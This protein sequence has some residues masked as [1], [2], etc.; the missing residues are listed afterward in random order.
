MGRPYS[1][2]LRVRVVAAMEGGG[3]CRTVGAAFGIAPSTAGNRHRL[4]RRTQGYSARPMGGDRRSKLLDHDAHVAALLADTC[5][6]R[7]VDV[8]AALAERGVFVSWSTVRRRV[9]RLGLRLKKKRYSRRNRIAL[10]SRWQ[11]S[12]G[13]RL[14]PVSTSPASCL[15][16]RPEPIPR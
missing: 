4:Y 11:G 9:K 2:D 14:R 5:D 6:L 16:M 3:D 12:C 10:T 8:Q 13:K 1:D 15:L 7:L